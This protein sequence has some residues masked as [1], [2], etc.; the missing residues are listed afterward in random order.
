MALS[1]KLLRILRLLKAAFCVYQSLLG[2]RYLFQEISRNNTWRKAFSYYVS[3]NGLFSTFNHL[4]PFTKNLATSVRLYRL[5]SG[6]SR[7]TYGSCSPETS[8]GFTRS[9][10]RL[11]KPNL[12]IVLHVYH[13]LTSHGYTQ[14][15][16]HPQNFFLM[17]LC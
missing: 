2:S 1:I 11:V 15:L 14:N 13:V 8:P 17:L 10:I 6:Q 12:T 4:L 5:K 16:T 3:F 7:V 9:P